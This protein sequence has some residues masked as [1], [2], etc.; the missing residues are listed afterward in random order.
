MAHWCHCH[1]VSLASVKSRL[2]LP[3]YAHPGS[4]GKRAIKRVCVC[5]MIVCRVQISLQVKYKLKWWKLIHS[6]QTHTSDKWSAAM[7]Q[8]CYDDCHLWTVNATSVISTRLNGQLIKTNKTD[9]SVDRP[10]RSTQQHIKCTSQT[11][12]S[13]STAVYLPHCGTVSGYWHQRQHTSNATAISSQ[14]GGRRKN[15]VNVSFSW[16]GSVIWVLFSVLCCWG[17]R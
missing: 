13:H 12:C 7:W 4:P 6:E 8:Q 17:D 3:Y 16:P 10:Q 1:S 14:N 15:N 2:V 5:Y 9:E 11:Q